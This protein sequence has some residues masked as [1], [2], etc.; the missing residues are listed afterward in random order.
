MTKVFI[1]VVLFQSNENVSWAYLFF[2]KVCV[3]VCEIVFKGL[4]NMK[5][6]YVV[7]W[8]T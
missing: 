4:F 5:R 1:P 6:S 8:G 7:F 2:K 3:S